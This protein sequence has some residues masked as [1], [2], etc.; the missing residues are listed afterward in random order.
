MRVTDFVVG[1]VTLCSATKN[2]AKIADI[3]MRHAIPYRCPR[4]ADGNFLIECDIGSS[5]RLAELCSG[6]GIELSVK[7]RVGFPVFF[8]RWKDRSVFSSQFSGNSPIFC[9]SLGQC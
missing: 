3:C 7:R 4:F 9:F 8:E 1:K 2:S 5:K 6:R